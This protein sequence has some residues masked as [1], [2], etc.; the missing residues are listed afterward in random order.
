[1]NEEEKDQWIL[2]QAAILYP[3]K[4]SDFLKTL[5]NEKI[6]ID[7]PDDEEF[8]EFCNNVNS[9]KLYIEYE[10]WYQEFEDGYYIDDWKEKFY[11][12]CHVMAYI[13]SIL[14]IC[15]QLNI[16]GYYDKV[17]EYIQSIM[18]LEFHVEDTFDSEMEFDE[19]Y[20]PFTI[21]V[22]YKYYSNELLYFSIY[23]MAYDWIYAYCHRESQLSIDEKANELLQLFLEPL[24]DK[25]VFSDFDCI[26]KELREKMLFQLQQLIRNHTNIYNN[27][28]G[29]KY[30]LKI[31]I[32]RATQ[33]LDDLKIIL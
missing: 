30:D 4:R 25:V 27:Y 29:D 6:I 10:T 14:E 19:G 31:K 9:G 33:L 1:M 2:N 15:H 17:Y 26:D 5:R 24:C 11:D 23:Q 18:Q 32:E 7:M 13:D 8:K 22:I 3:S 28:S 21:D 20:L 16:L 12:S